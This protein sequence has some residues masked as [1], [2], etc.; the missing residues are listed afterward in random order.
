VIASTAFKTAKFV[1]IY[2][3]VCF[4]RVRSNHDQYAFRLHGSPIHTSIS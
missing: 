1:R 2:Y 4:V 3:T